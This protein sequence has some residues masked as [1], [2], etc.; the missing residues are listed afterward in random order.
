LTSTFGMCRLVNRQLRDGQVGQ[1]AASGC[2]GWLTGS[3]GDVQVR[4]RKLLVTTID[5]IPA[6]PAPAQSY[7][8]TDSAQALYPRP[9]LIAF[10]NIHPASLT[11]GL[12]LEGNTG[13]GNSS[14]VCPQ[15]FATCPISVL[16]V[17]V[18]C[19]AQSHGL[20]TVLYFCSETPVT[21]EML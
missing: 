8:G 13:V 9:T 21:E 12:A 1:Q 14:Q 6:V 7:T 11:S 19:F 17:D 4:T 15:S 2:A 3:F 16:A 20:P 18:V 5:G 10:P